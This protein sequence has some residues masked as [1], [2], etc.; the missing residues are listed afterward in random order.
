[1]TTFNQEQQKG[2]NKGISN[3]LKEAYADGYQQG[4]KWGTTASPGAKEEAATRQ[5]TNEQIKSHLDY[6]ADCEARGLSDDGNNMVL[7]PYFNGEHHEE[8]VKFFSDVIAQPSYQGTA[9]PASDKGI[10]HDSYF[11]SDMPT[12]EF[13]SF[14]DG[15]TDSVRN[16][17]GNLHSTN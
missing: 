3:S 6:Y 10:C 7:P 13:R 11:L 8:I 1:M 16:N 15:W 2:A 12:A 14:E 9:E 4:E 5:T 17:G